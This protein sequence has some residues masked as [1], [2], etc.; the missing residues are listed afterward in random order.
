MKRHFLVTGGA[1]FIGSNYI[2]RLLAQEKKVTILDNMS[3]A[4]ADLNIQWLRERFGK[5]SFNL[6]QADIRDAEQV[7]SAAKNVD[8]IIHLAAQ[9]TVTTSVIN[10]REDFEINALGTFNVMEAARLSKKNP[11][12]LYSSTNKVYGEMLDE[13]IIEEK[14]QYRY[15]GLPAG[16]SESQRLDFH[17]PYGC[18]KGS[19]DQYVRDYYRIFGIPSVVLRQSCIYG[20]R[21]F[22]IEDQ[23]WVA[24]FVIAAILGKEITIYGDG[25]QVRDALYIDDLLDVYDLVVEKI[26]KTAGQVYNI[27]GG[28]H[29]TISIWQ[30]F[31][32]ILED[33][34]GKNIEVRRN[35]WRPGDQKIYVSDICKAQTDLGWEPKVDVL[36]GIHNLFDWVNTNKQLF[37][38]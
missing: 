33:L 1:G 7:H 34:V 38:D 17:S 6:I 5:D 21:Q 31:S 29:N 23:G 13:K 3:R 27:G 8:V 22:G 30:Q 24:W 18:S 4:G 35:G 32:P 28:P 12:V 20:P 26:D 14:D 19:G 11:I 25:K 15:A 9:V 36:E 16:V 2:A 10:P 37:L